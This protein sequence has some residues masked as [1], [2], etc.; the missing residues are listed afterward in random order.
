MSN[1]YVPKSTADRFVHK[2]KEDLHILDLFARSDK[3]RYHK[4]KNNNSHKIDI[5]LRIRNIMMTTNKGKVLCW[6]WVHSPP[7]IGNHFCPYINDTILQVRMLPELNEKGKRLEKDQSMGLKIKKLR[8]HAFLR[9]Y[10]N[11]SVNYWKHEFKQSSN[12]LPC[13]Y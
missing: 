11:A 4:W 1:K 6:L 8:N 13:D 10:I 7:T 12:V 9:Y 2:L 5:Y 3:E